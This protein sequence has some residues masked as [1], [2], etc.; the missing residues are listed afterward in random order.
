[1]KRL[2]NDGHTVVAVDI[3]PFSDW[4]FADSAITNLTLD[5]TFSD[6]VAQLANLPITRVYNL[7]AD[8]GGMGFIENNKALCMVSSLINTNLLRT[9]LCWNL[10]SYF[11]ASSAC[12]YSASKQ[13]WSEDIGLQEEDIWPIDPEDGYGWEKLFSERMCRHFSED[14]NIPVRIARYH[15]V[16][17]PFGTFSGG[18][19]KVIGA[20]CRKIAY[21]KLTENYEVEIWG[22]GTQIRSF[23]YV[24]DSVEGT[25]RLSKSGISEPLNIGSSESVTVLDLANTIAD[26]AGFA[27]SYTFLHNAPKGVP[28][29]NS[30]NR[31]IQK[32]LGWSPSTPLIDG[33]EVTYKWIEDQVVASNGMNV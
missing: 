12:V 32:L 1:M 28:A 4:Y 21:A 3:K 14:F 19:E 24:D 25:I 29:R 31:K 15:N 10:E 11:F 30:D 27:P 16:Y 5:L 20:L 18:R 23:T 8:M 26:I 17:G 2:M 7:A 22:D 33:L 6:Q 9:A 13:H